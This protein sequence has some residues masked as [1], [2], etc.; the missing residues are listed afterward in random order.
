MYD[1]DTFVLIAPDCP[2]DRGVVPESKREP[3][4]F[5]VAHFEVLSRN[6]YRFRF[7]ESLV[8]AHLRQQGRFDGDPDEL[9][10]SLLKKHPCPRCSALPKRCGWGIHIDGDGRL[11]LWGA[12]SAEYRRLTRPGKGQP[13]LVAALRSK[14]A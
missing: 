1:R 11:A 6:P 14:R 12:E 13:Q 4:P 7:G 9:L 5:H 10:R 3:V 8:E 2:V